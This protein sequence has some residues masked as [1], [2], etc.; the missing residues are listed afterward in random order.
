LSISQLININDSL[1]VIGHTRSAVRGDKEIGTILADACNNKSTSIGVWWLIT[2]ILATTLTFSFGGEAEA[3][4]LREALRKTQRT[5]PT[6]RA[7]KFSTQAAR[8]SVNQ[9]RAG[10]KP[11]VRF[12]ASKALDWSNTNISPYRLSGA[13]SF[14]I[15]LTKPLYDGGRNRQEI[16]QAQANVGASRQ[17]SLAAEQ[18]TLFNA[19]QAYMNV[20]RD[21]KILAQRRSNVDVL[22]EQARATKKRFDVGEVTKTDV[23]QSNARVS[24][25]RAAVA[26]AQAQLASSEASF[27]E[28]I[29]MQPQSL[30][31][32]QSANVPNSLASALA[33]A[34]K[35]NPSILAAAFVEDAAR[36][37]KRA[38]QSDSDWQVDL[39]ANASLSLTGQVQPTR[40]LILQETAHVDITAS[41]QLYDGGLNRS[42]VRQAGQ[43]ASQRRIEKIGAV[44]NV[45]EGVKVAWG[46]YVATAQ[47]I[48]GAQAQVNA[49]QQALDG[50]RTEYA[51]GS[52]STID[53]LN[54]QQELITAQIALINAQRDRVVASYQLLAAMGRLT[55]KGLGL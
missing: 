12:S 6:I 49:T 18:N 21:R 33:T 25:A 24:G 17:Q 14:S 55:G 43:V 48:T 44:R 38:L 20:L 32:P 13:E 54:T 15:Q 47:A 30:T 8:E 26:G 35:L 40:D 7:G 27:E 53:V 29:G 22:T 4:S 16:K 19:V 10:W 3:Q 42:R 31:W 52:R 5:H 46:N 9:A 45:R 11:Q 41:K 23:A 2:G 39:N 51:V 34:H 37:N 50:V 1:G 28:L 36:H